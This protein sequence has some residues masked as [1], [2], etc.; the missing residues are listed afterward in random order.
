[1]ATNNGQDDAV[2]AASAA[3][4]TGEMRGRVCL[5]TGATGG[6][7]QVAARALAAK[8]AT[9]VLT[10]RDATRAEEVVQRIRHETGNTQVN[11]LLADL[12]SQQ[13]VRRLAEEFQRSYPALHVL[14]NNAGGIFMRRLVTVDGYEMTFAL[15]HLAPF[16]LTNLLLD[17]LKA[18]A[19]ARVVTVSSAAHIGARIHF[20]DLMYS[21]TPYR[22]MGAYGQSKLANAMFAYELARRLQGTG[23]TSNALHPGFVAT[24]FAKNNGTLY[25]YGMTLLRPFAISP[26]RGA[27][28]TIYLASAPEAADVTGQYFVR[29]R[30][31]KSSKVS[32]DEEA[33]RRLWEVSE[34]LT[35]LTVSAHAR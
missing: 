28:T 13:Q 12:S 6:I 10:A 29:R 30:P 27:W 2:S 5:V 24:G 9:V 7:G 18:S 31:A 1:M 26:E 23:V 4:A 8:G 34:E 20:D 11:F 32:H 22:P 17:E 14:V 19:P 3:S 16:L 35:G 33:Q 21:H 15:N 25:Q